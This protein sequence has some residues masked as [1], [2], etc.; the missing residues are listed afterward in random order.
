[1]KKNKMKNILGIILVIALIVSPFQNTILSNASSYQSG[2]YE[3]I[4]GILKKYNGNEKVVKIPVGVKKI[5]KQAFYW[6]DNIEE[7]DIPEEVEVIEEKSFYVCQNLKKVNIPGSV[8]KVDTRIFSWCDKLEEIELGEGIEELGDDCFS[9][10]KNIKEISIPGSVKK[11]GAGAFNWCDSLEK[12]KLGEGTEEIG[13]NCFSSCVNLKE[14]NIP[15]SV[16][17]IGAGAFNWCDSLEKVKLGEGTE[18][19]GDNCFSSCA[20]LKSI[21]MPQSI[22]KI[23]S[24]VLNWCNEKLNIECYYGSMAHNYAKQ[25]N[26]TIGKL[27]NIPY[28]ISVNSYLKKVVDISTQKKLKGKKITLETAITNNAEENYE[29]D[30]DDKTLTKLT[31]VNITINLPSELKFENGSNKKTKKFDEISVGATKK[32]QDKV[33]LV[34]KVTAD[35]KL[36]TTISL[37]ADNY[38]KEFSYNLA[39]FGLE[40]K[41]TKEEQNNTKLINYK[42]STKQKIHSTECIATKDDSRGDISQTAEYKIG[43]DYYIFYQAVN[44]KYWEL[45]GIILDK[46][47][48]VKK[49]IDFPYIKNYELFGN[50]IVDNTGKIYVICGHY[51]KKHTEENNTKVMAIV[52]YDGNAKEIKRTVFSSNETGSDGFGTKIPFDAGECA[53]VIDKNDRL[54]CDYA[55]I[56]YNG[57]QSS[58]VIGV[59]INTMEKL[60]FNSP[61]CSHSF[62]QQAYAVENNALL[63]VNHGDAS[64]RAL[65]VSKVSSDLQELYSYDVF[66]YRNSTGSYNH[67]FSNFGGVSQMKE[68]YLLAGAS[69]KTLS[70]DK[71]RRGS[72]KERNLYIQLLRKDFENYYSNKDLEL[73]SADTRYAEGSFNYDNY[74]NATFNE[75]NK[76]DYL[77]EN[78]ADYGVKWLTNYKGSNYVS[79]SKIVKLDDNTS[80]VFFEKRNSTKSSDKY[81]G[82]YFCIIDQYGKILQGETS[83]KARL[84]NFD[85]MIYDNNHIYW[86]T[87]NGNNKKG[88]ILHS[89]KIMQSN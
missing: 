48:K 4:D 13:K 85:T 38:T 89:L 60:E 82:T 72:V 87:G 39:S 16:K 58:N 42:I 80:A 34:K 31:N 1:M 51:D 25:K 54:F 41:A 78:V 43:D 20:N 69:E 22:K 74:Y 36:K 17:K 35:T 79:A 46:K 2:K 47:F 29:Y 19:I 64:P 45:H 6:N 86:T 66:H 24:G 37:K 30:E 40:K 56:M 14:I 11:I 28:N 7:V 65:Q 15:G 8:K 12:V 83:V 21:N 73:L 49:R 27:H 77:P 26:I 57:H 52:K 53:L 5:A 63:F 76:K 84:S 88:L 71:Q 50:V 18:E 61:Y 59:N 32:I 75:H 44:K 23:G 62:E 9:G 70:Y 68:G 67:T 81:I 10:Y 55:R 33:V 3:I